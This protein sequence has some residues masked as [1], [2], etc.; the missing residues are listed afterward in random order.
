[1][2]LKDKVALVTGGG[3]DIAAAIAAKFLENGA[4]VVLFD[5]DEQQLN[6]VAKTLGDVDRLA[7]FPGDVRSLEALL[8]AVELAERRFGRLDTLVTCAGVLKHM[9]ID[10]LS[11]DDW[12]RVLGINLT[13]TFLACKAAVPKMKSHGGGRIITISSVG[14]RTGRPH[15]GADYAAAKAGVVGMTQSLARELGPY[16]INV[17]SIAPGPL[18]GRMTAQLP[19]EN[20]KVLISTA[21]IG[22]LGRPDDIAHAAV[23]LASDEAEWM[24]GEVLDVNGGVFI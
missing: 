10:Q 24:T 16:G 1:M 6:S 14:G 21:C 7:V 8:G 3:G 9:S 5:V 13:G 18:A 15:V 19:P 22:R 4:A 12:D 2:R 11:I 20:L 23:Y 17:N